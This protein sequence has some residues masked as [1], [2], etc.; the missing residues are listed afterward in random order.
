DSDDLPLNVSREML[1]QN[2][3]LDRIRGACVKRVLDLIER[4][5]REEPEKFATFYQA[6]GNTLKEGIVEDPANRERIA[7]LL[8]FASTRGGDEAPTVSLDEYV[9]RM[10]PGQDTI[11]VLTADGYRAA[12]GSPLLEA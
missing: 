12:A 9:G 2:R 8:R 6:F 3:Q 7:K 10:A 1:Q 4:L 11:W 5:A